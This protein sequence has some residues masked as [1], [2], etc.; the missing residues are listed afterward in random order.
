MEEPVW[1]HIHNGHPAPVWMPEPQL[2]HFYFLKGLKQMYSDLKD[3]SL[4]KLLELLMDREAWRAAVHGKA[5]S[6]T[7]PSHWTTS[8]WA[9]W[10][11]LQL[12]KMA[13][14]S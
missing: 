8:K 14:L 12:I 6:W 7:Q 3:M 1:N 9:D 2:L 5:K 13:G 11:K 4:I 10:Q